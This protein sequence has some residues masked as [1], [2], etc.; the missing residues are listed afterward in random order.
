[1]QSHY[2]AKTGPRPKCTMR[3]QHVEYF[4]FDSFFFYCR[5]DV[6]GKTNQPCKYCKVN[7]L[8]ILCMF[9]LLYNDYKKMKGLFVIDFISFLAFK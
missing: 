5:N 1:M 9:F 2:L 4:I 6:W 3:S 7:S 8:H